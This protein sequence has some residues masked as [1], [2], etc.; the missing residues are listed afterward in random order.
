M[1]DYMDIE[2]YTPQYIEG[3]GARAER[4]EIAL[5][6]QPGKETANDRLFIICDAKCKDGCGKEVSQAMILALGKWFDENVAEGEPVDESLLKMAMEDA[7]KELEVAYSDKNIRLSMGLL[8]L[9]HDG[10]TV[11]NIGDCQLYHARTKKNKLFLS[12]FK[13]NYE[14]LYLSSDQPSIWLGKTDCVNPEVVHIADIQPDDVFAICNAGMLEMDET[15]EETFIGS[16]MSHRIGVMNPKE[17]NLDYFKKEI[18]RILCMYNH[19]A[20]IVK[21]RNV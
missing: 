15:G 13:K 9:H 10:V 20:W 11:A 5:W 4:Q 18:A 17:A 1:K 16:I 7:C 6:P 19:S 21:I 12:R 8:Y 3:I 14:I 2:I